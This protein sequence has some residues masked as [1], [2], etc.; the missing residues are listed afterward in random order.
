[1]PSL[2]TP[3]AGLLCMEAQRVNSVKAHYTVEPTIVNS[4]DQLVALS[5][6]TPMPC[7][8]CLQREIRQEQM[9]DYKC[10]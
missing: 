1:M 5:L 3:T 4:V 2:L 9:Y 6:C 8:N 7:I 10:V